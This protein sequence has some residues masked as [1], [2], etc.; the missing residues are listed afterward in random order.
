M[1][2]REEL[3]IGVEQTVPDHRNENHDRQPSPV[4]KLNA[5][6]LHNQIASVP[7]LSRLLVAVLGSPARGSRDSATRVDWRASSKPPTTPP[8][9][10]GPVSSSEHLISEREDQARD[11]K[12]DENGGRSLPVHAE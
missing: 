8:T 5:I 11:G 12:G 2:R 7:S 10:A 4:A 1:Q 3:S 6:A 9:D